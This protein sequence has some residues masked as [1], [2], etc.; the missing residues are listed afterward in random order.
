MHTFFKFWLSL[1]INLESSIGKVY[2]RVL[3]Y[4][5]CSPGQGI[6]LQS[7]TDL[8]FRAY[9]DSDWASCP[10]TRHFNCLHDLCWPFSDFVGNQRKNILF[11][12]HPLRL[13]IVPW[14][15]F[16]V[17][18]NGFLYLKIFEFLFLFLL[19]SFVIIRRHDIMSNLL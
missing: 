18:W 17:N 2:I 11:Y 19:L 4:L 16:I 8:T 13:N 12:G 1:C 7:N 10:I 15:L 6:F 3:H 14:R 9:C 5:T